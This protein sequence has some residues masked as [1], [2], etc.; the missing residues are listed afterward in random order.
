MSE[1]KPRDPQLQKTLRRD[2][3]AEGIGVHS[4]RPAKLRL[5]PA[6]VNHGLVFVR[7]DLEGQPEIPALPSQI[8]TEALKR[9]TVLE[10]KDWKGRDPLGFGASVG[11]IEHLLAGCAG[12]EINNLRIELNGPECPI[13]DGSGIPYAR[14]F[15]EAGL[16]TQSERTRRFRLRKPVALLR[17]HAEIVA[18]PMRSTRYAFFAE[19]RHAGLRDQQATFDPETDD[20]AEMVA[21][22]RTFC[23]WKDVEGLIAAGLIKGGSTDNAIVLKDGEPVKVGEDKK[24]RRDNDFEYRFENELARHKLLDLIGDLAILGGQVSAFITAR[25]SGHALHQEFAAMLASEIEP[26]ESA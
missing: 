6:P 24:P 15:N 26:E 9:M 20:Y 11:M 5:V 12:M 17:D 16:E 2:I 22:A 18:I 10:R 25:A 4:G 3:E 19:F 23:F 13:F 21:P 8:K 1:S 7:T 14:L